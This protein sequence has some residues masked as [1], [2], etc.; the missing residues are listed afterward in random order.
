MSSSDHYSRQ[1]P[2]LAGWFG[3]VWAMVFHH[4]VMVLAFLMLP[5]L[6]LLLLF[7]DLLAPYDPVFQNVSERLSPPS[8]EY[9]FG[10]D[11][12]GRDI[13]SRVVYGARVSFL[14][15]FL[16]IVIA[17]TF[18]VSVGTFS[19]YCGGKPDLFIQ[20]FIDVL[21]GFPLLVIVVI[22]AVA[23]GPSGKV[24]IVSIALGLFPQIARLSRA[25]SLAIK[26]SDYVDAARV[27]GSHPLRIIARHI[28]PNSLPPVLAQIIGYFGVAV[29]AETAISFIGLGVPPPTPS[30]GRMIQ[31]GSR[32][33]F[34]VAPWATVFPG[35]ALSVTVFISVI[36]GDKTQNW[37]R[38]K[39]SPSRKVDL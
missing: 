37:V 24:M 3:I 12:F 14:V 4:P 22:I 35:L 19:A 27:L 39:T 6:T 38:L 28:L 16:A 31:E 17:G 9:Y 10:T 7:P 21:L 26:E 32:H 34:E 33:Y 20:R 5:L 1:R 2:F 13:F 15:G 11:G 25:S 8:S 30:W 23:M 29:V 18:G 36:L